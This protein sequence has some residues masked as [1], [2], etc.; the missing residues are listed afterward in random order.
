MSGARV[1]DP[2][3]KPTP[4]EIRVFSE[5][6]ARPYEPSGVPVRET[7]AACGGSGVIRVTDPNGGTEK[8]RCPDCPRLRETEAT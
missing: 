4:E 1:R 6:A 5:R 8:E 7:C 2:G 3:A